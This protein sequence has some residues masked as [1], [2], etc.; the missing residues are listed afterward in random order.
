MV[1]IET[2]NNKEEE[3]KASILSDDDKIAV[4]DI[5][6]H[7]REG[8][9]L[10]PWAYWTN[11]YGLHVINDR[12]RILR[13]M[14]LKQ[15]PLRIA[16]PK[17]YYSK[18]TYGGT[19]QDYVEDI[20]TPERDPGI[21]SAYGA[22]ALIVE[23]LNAR[24]VL[25]GTELWSAEINNSSML[26]ML[27]QGRAE[28]GGGVLRILHNR[29]TRLDY[30][31]SIWPFRVGFTY[32]SERES[33]SNM[34]V[35]PFAA[36]VWWSCLALV[37]VLAAAQRLMANTPVEKE[38]AYISVLATYLQQDA[39]AVPE[40]T[41]GRLTF[42]VLSI[43]SML[44]HAYYTSAIVSAL[45][46]TGR[47]GP[48]SLTSLANSK[49]AISSED[50]DYM[51][52]LMFDV[53]TNRDDLEY[54]KKKKKT[55]KFYQGIERGVQLIQEGNTAYHTEYNQLYPRMKFF[56]DDQICKLQYVD[57][58]PEL[59]SLNE[60]MNQM[61]DTISE[62]Y[63]KHIDFNMA[64][65]YLILALLIQCSLTYADVQSPKNETESIEIIAE[66][67]EIESS[68]KDNDKIL[69]STGVNDEKVEKVDIESDNPKSDT[70]DVLI[71]DFRTAT[72]DWVDTFLGSSSSLSPSSSVSLMAQATNS[73]KSPEE[74]LEE[75]KEV[76]SEIT[77]AIQSEVTN[78][79]SYAL[80]LVDKDVED[81]NRRKRRSIETPMDSSQLVMK[82]LNH[83]KSNNEY[84]NIAIEKM[85]SAQEIADK[86]GIEFSPDPEIL[87][88][89]AFA[90]NEQ[91]KELTSILLDACDIQ[92][93]SCSIAV[94]DETVNI[95]GNSVPMDNATCYVFSTEYPDCDTKT[96]LKSSISESH[97][98]QF[99]VA[100]TVPS[101]HIHHGDNHAGFNYYSYPYETQ[102]ASPPVQPS[103]STVSP[104]PT[105]YDSISY[106]PNEY[107][108]PYCSMDQMAYPMYPFEEPL[109]L[110]PELVG[111]EYEEIVSSRV[112][113][114]QD[115][116]PG[117]ATVNH[118]MTYTVSEKAH[119]RTPQ[120]EKLPQQMQYYFFLM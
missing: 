73:N 11:T 79:L 38:G 65:F 19:F 23:S 117:S 70:E 40:G 59:L 71:K 99:Q 28:L 66:A 68:A 4:Q 30:A 90:A 47:N 119:F 58:I 63:E 80:N 32:V 34:F 15:H 111:E 74:Q 100:P 67:D 16:A 8:I 44:V 48:D 97:E 101:N 86:Y 102:I 109:D 110:Q 51:K 81:N 18:E 37:A 41:S 83:I 54:L 7:P 52:Y 115:E 50:Y 61:I 91:A 118:V 105:F 92:N 12:Q 25:I 53:E 42:I 120:I 45:M 62:R 75:I 36:A 107:Y 84:Q 87:S 98:H 77:M 27:E 106:N 72:N 82:L 60:R 116:E 103:Y 10:H 17:G 3:E 20:S 64:P 21:R 39:S 89:L 22:A 93:S 13:R 31:M 5:F 6:I 55:S 96:K 85:M 43:S 69:K 26:L 104:K 113:I 35:E 57:T 76:A 88:D 1:L 95:T 9:S 108:G 78:L 24:E 46:S 29:I 33:S 2:Q 114:E 112:I 49:Y 94:Q 56:T 14:D